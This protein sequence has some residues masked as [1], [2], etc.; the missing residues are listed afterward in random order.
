MLTSKQ[1]SYKD[2]TSYTSLLDIIYPVGS[3]CLF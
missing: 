1:I 3:V 2:N